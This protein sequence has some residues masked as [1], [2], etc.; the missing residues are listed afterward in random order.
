MGLSNPQTIADP[1]RRKILGG[2]DLKGGTGIEIGALCRP[3]VTRDDG[4]IIYVDHTSTDVL[5]VKYARDPN[6]DV[7][8]IVNVDAVWGAN[9]LSEAVSGRKVDYIVASHVIEHVPDLVTWLQELHSV[10][11]P[12]GQVRLIIPDKRFTFDYLREES[13]MAD[14]LTAFVHRA[15]VPQP[16]S[17]IDF[18]LGA[19]EVSAADAWDRVLPPDHLKHHYKFT[20]ALALSRD[21]IANGT[22][23][24]VHCWTFT[25]RSFSRIMR[26]LVHHELVGFSCESFH[27]T[28]RNTLEFFVTLK[29]TDDREAAEVSWKTMEA[30]AS[31]AVPGKPF[32]RL[33]RALGW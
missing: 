24:D 5:K 20:D 3:I 11:K 12:A 13:R 18:A 29:A 14:I 8:K 7:N 22:Y 26:S 15:R 19:S 30:R 16:H 21:V 27:D 31:D 9:T 32:W 6:V 2:L 25:P 4:E 17:I 33:R 10:L 1:R 23:H 28:E